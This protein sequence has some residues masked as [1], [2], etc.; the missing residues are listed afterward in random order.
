M[1][2]RRPEA[3]AGGVATVFFAEI[4]RAADAVARA[5][6]LL[7]AAGAGMGVDSGMP[8]FRGGAGFW[9]AYPAAQKLGLAFEEIPGQHVGAGDSRFPIVASAVVRRTPSVGA[10]DAGAR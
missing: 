7:I 5:D 9:Q 3:Y 4:D 10:T 8:D 1:T 2:W 6:A